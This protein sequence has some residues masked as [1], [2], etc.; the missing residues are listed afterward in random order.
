MFLLRGDV[1]EMTPLYDILS[2]WPYIGCGPRQLNRHRAGLAMALRSKK[3]ALPF[4]RDSCATL[5]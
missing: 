3:C 5:A 1:Y 2:A 4:Q